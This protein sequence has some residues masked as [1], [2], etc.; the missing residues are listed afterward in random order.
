MTTPVVIAQALGRLAI[1]YRLDRGLDETETLTHDWGIALREYPNPVFEAA[2]ETW[3]IISQWHPTLAEI[4]DAC[5]DEAAM[6]K[7][8]LR[9]E[10]ARELENPEPEHLADAHTAAKAIRAAAALRMPPAAT[11][12]EMATRGTM[13]VSLLGPR[14]ITHEHRDG[15]ANCSICSRHDHSSAD[16]RETCPECGV[17]PV[18]LYRWSMCRKCDGSGWMEVKNGS[19]RPC[20]D[21][22]GHA[23]ALWAGGHYESGH[24]C[25]ECST[26]PGRKRRDD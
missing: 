6:R 3:I 9:V 25:E 14:S 24:R 12:E 5:V 22:N 7:E 15:T 4:I 10:R 8:F 2:V 20:E 26:R 21:C 1:H 16:W 11:W 18:P 19:V 17:A 23:H 13:D